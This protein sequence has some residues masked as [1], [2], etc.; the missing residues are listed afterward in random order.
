MCIV[1]IFFSS[2]LGH[3][4]SSIVLFRMTLIPIDPISNIQELHCLTSKRHIYNMYIIYIHELDFSS[5][6]FLPCTFAVLLSIFPFFAEKLFNFRSCILCIE[7]LVLSVIVMYQ[8]LWICIFWG[9]YVLFTIITWLVFSRTLE[10]TIITWLVFI[11][12]PLL[13]IFKYGKQFLIRHSF[14]HNYFMM[15]LL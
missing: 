9:W 3:C 13:A 15:K 6:S 14:H 1:T 8:H 10:V 4:N 7:H 5:F 2:L 11:R 12:T